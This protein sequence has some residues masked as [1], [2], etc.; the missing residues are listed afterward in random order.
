MCT[1]LRYETWHCGTRLE[2][3]MDLF[4]YS[5]ELGKSDSIPV[6]RMKQTRNTTVAKSGCTTQLL[7]R[8]CH[9]QPAGLY[10]SFISITFSASLIH[11][12]TFFI[13]FL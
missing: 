10:F 6:I 9:R 1:G 2:A 8:T 7:I 13:F 11:L 3:K 5:I 12:L 4:Q